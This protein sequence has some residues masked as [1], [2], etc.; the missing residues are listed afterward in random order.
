MYNNTPKDGACPAVI[1]TGSSVPRHRL[2]DLHVWVCPLY[3]LDPKIQQGKKLPRLEPRSKRLMFLGISQQ[4][5]TE[6]PLIL[7][8]GNGII[9]TNFHGV[10]FDDLFTT[11]PS[12]ERDTAP[13]DH[14]EELCL[15]N[16]THSM[17]DLPPEHLDDEW[18]IE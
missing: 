10:V 15:E 1:F 18:L 2:V 5:S 4:N 7:N 14:W 8:L 16:L 17:L 6:V 11:L 3:V 9:T 13:H 12:I